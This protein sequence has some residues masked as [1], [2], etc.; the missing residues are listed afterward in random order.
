MKWKLFKNMAAFMMA[1]LGMKEIPIKDQKIEFSE[2]QKRKLQEALGEKFNL[3]ELTE[4]MNQEI[5]D[6]LKSEDAK[7]QELIDLR[8][9][10]QQELIEHGLSQEDSKSLI[11]NPDFAQTAT[12]KEI[13][14]GLLNKID[15]MSQKADLQDKQLQQL[16]KEPEGDNPIDRGTMSKKGINHSA[17]HLFGDS[18]PINAFEGR[19]W[20]QLAA[21]QKADFP[22]FAIGSTEVETL[23]NDFELYNRQVNSDLKS[24]FRD[25]LKLPT[26]WPLRS[27]VDDKV[28]DG[29]VVTAEITQAR[30]KGWL[31]KNKQMIQPEEAKVYPAQIDIEHA[32]YF[33]QAQLTSWISQYNKE[34]SQAYKWTFVQFL[35]TEIDKRRAQEDRIVAIR[36]VHVPTP[37]NATIPGLAIHRGDGILIKLWKALH[38]DKKY[39]AAQIGKPTDS[40]IVDYV[41]EN[42]E[43]NLPEEEK[44]NAG[45]V[46][47]LSPTWLR[48][49]V[50]K[51]RILFGQ[52]NNYTGQELLEIENYP[53][54]KFCPLVDLEGTDFHF[55]TYEDNIELMENVPGERN[56]YHLESQKR[57]IYIFGDYK[58]GPRIKH[59]GTKVKDGDPAAFKVQTVWSNGLNPFKEDFYARL[60]DNGTGEI[61]IPYSNITITDDYATSID[62]ITGTYQ[63]QIVRIKGNTSVA[64]AVKVTDD[65]NITLAANADFNLNSGGVLTL[66]VN[67]DG[68]LTEIKRTNEAPTAPSTDVN[69]T[70]TAIDADEGY[71][72]K[73]TDAGDQIMTEILNGIEGQIIDIY[74]GEGGSLTVSDVAGNIEVTAD[75]VLALA[76]DTI[77]LQLVDGVWLEVSRDISA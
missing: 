75:A 54:V 31:P 26:F 74:G 70:T 42:I 48:K 41:K 15:Q 76:T 43:K 13:L 12:E 6:S 64:A 25:N 37:E 52:D 24:L 27:N 59:I 28:A 51:K 21:G 16:L 9:K 8:K 3:E 61:E 23:K 45:F 10:A 36:G 30:K 38:I 71:V 11:D 4:K 29:N 66:R 77:K 57:D 44:N 20:N 33:L 18:N 49:H 32:G 55:I 22:T 62:T 73:Y 63:G 58:W 1:I 39:K 7:D 19:A 68:S 2:D 5:A 35:N 14:S 53:N 47:Y 17:T 67:S 46:Y 72:F 50:E 40:N 65:G 60:Y 56:M 69:F 34:G